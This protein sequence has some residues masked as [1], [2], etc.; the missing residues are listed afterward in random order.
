MFISTAIVNQSSYF[1]D[2]DLRASAS[3]LFSVFCMTVL[4]YVKVVIVI[5]CYCQSCLTFQLLLSY[6]LY[7]LLNM[8]LYLPLIIVKVASLFH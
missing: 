5:G 7:L 6:D 2:F 4:S 8:N 3:S 1:L